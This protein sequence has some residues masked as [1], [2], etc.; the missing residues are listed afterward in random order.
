MR[1]SIPRQVFNCR[2]I[3]PAGGTTNL[4]VQMWNGRVCL[5]PGCLVKAILNS[6]Y[7]RIV[8][9]LQMTAPHSGRCCCWFW[10]PD[11]RAQPL[12]CQCSS[13]PHTPTQLF[14][15]TF[16]SSCESRMGF[17]TSEPECQ[18]LMKAASHASSST[19]SAPSVSEQET[20]RA[21][22]SEVKQRGVEQRP[23]WRYWRRTGPEPQHRQPGGNK[24]WSMRDIWM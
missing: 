17:R 8:K 16:V 15:T 4:Q 23:P 22:H 24:N 7:D 2:L 11:Y 21:L 12:M 5:V 9:Q 3:R 1:S 19:S 10:T 18:E 14:P 20:Y 13:G 6:H